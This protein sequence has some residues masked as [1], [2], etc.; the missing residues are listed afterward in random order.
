MGQKYFQVY[1]KKKVFPNSLMDV[2]FES[3][4]RILSCSFRNDLQS[5]LYWIFRNKKRTIDKFK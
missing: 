3:L 5:L 2:Q 1:K 4:K